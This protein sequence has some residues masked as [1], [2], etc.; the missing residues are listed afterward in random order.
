MH[1]AAFEALGLD[2]VYLPLPAE[3]QNLSAALAG[4]KALSFSGCNVSVPYKTKVIQFLDELDETSRQMQAVNTIKIVDG[5]PI[6]SNT[7]PQGFT[8]HLLG[9]GI[10]PVGMKIVL[11]G[12]G[13]AAR[14]AVF[15]LSSFKVRQITVLDVVKSQGLSLIS[16]M[17]QLFPDGI[18][19]YQ[20]ITRETLKS[21]GDFDLVVNASPI[22]MTPNTESTP[23]PNDVDLPAKAVFY[24]IVYNPIETLFLSRAKQ[25]G[26]QTLNGL[27]M[28][29]NQGAASFETWT[30]IQP[31]IDLMLEVCEK[32]L[33]INQG[34]P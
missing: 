27:G 18:L 12:A 23:W 9:N 11:I 34:K 2:W 32:A 24:D 10:S 13:G 19:E 20:P 28:L 1:N 30:G 15:G 4:L 17:N 31:P 3:P 7:D 6:G 14:A 25:E 8:R 33:K 29:V 5:R 22:G 16:D 21:F 26:H